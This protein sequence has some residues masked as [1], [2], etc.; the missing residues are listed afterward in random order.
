MPES[1]AKKTISGV[2]YSIREMQSN[3]IAD[4]LKIEQE[5]ALSPWSETQF[6]AELTNTFS[7]SLIIRKARHIIAFAIVW[8]A[9]D[10]I[11]IA[12]VAISAASRRI[13]LATFLLQT[14]IEMARLNGSK[15]AH[16]EVRRSNLGAISLY[17]KIGF[18]ISGI[19]KNYYTSP[20]EDAY[21]MSA[22]C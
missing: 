14:I 12:N 22:M 4:V 11:Q 17:Q 19:R 8:S 2:E 20:K 3:D 6:R 7:K 9:A 5:S 1:I 10:E 13:G 18:E 16:L 21:L 15:T